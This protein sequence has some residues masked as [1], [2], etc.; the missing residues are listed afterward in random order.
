MTKFVGN[1]K[2]LWEA[3]EA[4]RAPTRSGLIGHQQ[5]PGSS[6]LQAGDN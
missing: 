6:H 3:L 5:S 1:R 2:V 4:T